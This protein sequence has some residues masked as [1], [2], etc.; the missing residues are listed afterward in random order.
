MFSVLVFFLLK[1]P[2]NTFLVRDFG[3][4]LLWRCRDGLVLGGPGEGVGD[5][6]VLWV[7]YV[8]RSVVSV[9]GLN[10]RDGPEDFSE[11]C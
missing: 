1:T 2:F 10:P 7:G 8:L 3:G 9:D 6:G 5:H 4:A 11:A